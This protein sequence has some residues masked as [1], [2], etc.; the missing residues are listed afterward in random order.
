MG[1]IF[2]FGMPRSGTSWLGKIFDSHPD[3]VFRH[4]PDIDFRNTSIPWYPEE[5]EPYLDEA[6]AYIAKLA[7][8]N[9]VK[10]RASLPLFPKRHLGTVGQ[11]LRYV[12][13]YGS[14]ALDRAGVRAGVPD[15]FSLKDQPIVIKSVSS[16]G[17]A[18]L[19]TEACNS[20]TIIIT[21]HPCG[22]IASQM[23]GIKMGKMPSSSY[24]WPLLG[25]VS[26]QYGLDRPAWEKMNLLENLSWKWVIANETAMSQCP[27]AYAVRHEDLC[28]RPIELAREIFAFAGLEWSEQTQRFLESSTVSDGANYFSVFRDSAAEANKWRGELSDEEINQI[29]SIT[30]NTPPGRMYEMEAE[31]NPAVTATS[32]S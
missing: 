15:F 16:M 12:C 20:K 7:R 8:V 25:S 23:R 3:V 10:S 1:Q 9:T 24:R 5:T 4:E 11:F 30:A 22:Q 2:V 26:T 14:R 28:D 13:V 32:P 6:R 31:L 19:Y 18:G 21:R 29:M 17:R 27:S